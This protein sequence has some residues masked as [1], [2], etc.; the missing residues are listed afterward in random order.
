MSVVRSSYLSIY[1]DTMAQS[2]CWKKEHGPC[3]RCTIWPL[4]DITITNIVWLDI[5]GCGKEGG[6]EVSGHRAD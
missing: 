4:H 2:F 3:E 5:S 1:R 6:R